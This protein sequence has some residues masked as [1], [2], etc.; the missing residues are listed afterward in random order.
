MAIARLHMKIGK[1]RN[2]SSH[3]SY[4]AR[5]GKYR[6]R[7]AQ[8][9]KLEH[10]EYG[11]M[12][13]WA[14]D[15][16]NLFWQSS[17]FY[18]RKNGTNYREMEIALPREL[19]AEQRKALVNEFVK[20]EI[21][22][23]HAYQYAIHNP[24]SLDGGE[25]PHVHLMFSERLNDGIDRD[26]EQYFK[27][28]NAKNPE[29]GGA[30]KHYGEVD[31]NLKL[32]KE[33]TEARTNE[34][35]QL[36]DRWEQSCNKHLIKHGYK[37]NVISM[38]SYKEQGINLLPEQKQLP[39]QWRN[40]TIKAEIIQFREAKADYRQADKELKQE[41]PNI[42][43]ELNLNIKHPKERA[44]IDWG[45]SKES[46][47][48]S[49]SIVE[50]MKQALEKN[51]QVPPSDPKEPTQEQI[52]LERIKNLSERNLKEKDRYVLVYKVNSLKTDISRLDDEIKTN[53]DLRDQQTKELRALKAQYEET[54]KGLL[55]FTKKEQRQHI[56][57]EFNQTKE[58]ERNYNGKLDRLEATK[59]EKTQ[60]R[61]EALKKLEKTPSVITEEERQELITLQEEQAKFEK[62][63]ARLQQKIQLE[64]RLQALKVE[65]QRLDKA[66]SQ[67][68]SKEQRYKELAEKNQRENE[69]IQLISNYETNKTLLAKTEQQINTLDERIKQQK[70]HLADEEKAYQE[71]Q[72]GLFSFMRK[73]E[74]K[75]QRF[76]A[77]KRTIEQ[78]QNDKIP[79]LRTKLELEERI[80]SQERQLSKLPKMS[81]QDKREYSQLKEQRETQQK[82]QEKIQQEQQK[83]QRQ[84]Q[85]IEQEKHPKQKQKG[86]GFEM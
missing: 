68:P 6:N 22:A 80:Q 76:K 86:F 55:A 48:S 79:L 19:N 53:T 66:N 5:E 71:T 54:Q 36:R 34:L 23:K 17:D 60:Q 7:L 85:R 39:S 84:Q 72:K 8:G 11:N 50:L 41:I 25:Q 64:E 16:P 21:G 51:R 3:A 49:L 69:R 67:D 42:K 9:E 74:Q 81:D 44:H 30:R 1:T 33:R 62:E 20:Q 43:G 58:I 82:Q 78:Q 12:P 29:K 32:S 83:I 4:I 10:T 47:A 57:A 15:D 59:A 31:A 18:E 56:E 26:P 46:I 14:N 37:D 61:E 77:Q 13:S 40:K 65:Q 2:A 24:K 35:K 73:D 38:K 52:R 27:R 28:Y 45:D 70:D 75:E 63:Q